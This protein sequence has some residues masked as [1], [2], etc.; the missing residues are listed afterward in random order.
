M[1]GTLPFRRRSRAQ[2]A[3]DAFTRGRQRVDSLAE[4]LSAEAV[5]AAAAGMA[6][7][8]QGI[9]RG[10]QGVDALAESL[11]A[12]LTAEAMAGVVRD[13]QREAVP[14]IERATGRTRR[15]KSRNRGLLTLA[16]LGVA[17]GVCYFLWQRRDE[18]PAY[19]MDEPERPSVAPA[20]SPAPSTPA[21]SDPAPAVGEDDVAAAQALARS[22]VERE[23]ASTH[24]PTAHRDVR[25]QQRP[26]ETRREGV[27]SL[28]S[29]LAG[30]SSVPWLPARPHMPGGSGPALPH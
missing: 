24:G 16:L 29:P 18:H 2:M 21:P 23:L 22:M 27:P 13:L 8:R 19:L 12:G 3:A 17:A 10:R 25:E 20:G 26:A 15:K 4:V 6:R 9:A 11:P 28:P 5:A 7:G 14:L 1:F 30:A